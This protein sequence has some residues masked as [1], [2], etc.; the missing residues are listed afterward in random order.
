M[1]DEAANSFQPGSS[2]SHSAREHGYVVC[3]VTKKMRLT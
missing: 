1:V 2:P 3:L